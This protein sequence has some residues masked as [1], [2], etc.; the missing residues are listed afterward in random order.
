MIRKQ[1]SYLKNLLSADGK[2]IEKTQEFGTW[3]NDNKGSSTNKLKVTIYNSDG[4]TVNSVAEYNV[5]CSL[6]ADPA[7]GEKKN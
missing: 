6:E 7:T 1:I 2:T 3:T 4:K 5:K